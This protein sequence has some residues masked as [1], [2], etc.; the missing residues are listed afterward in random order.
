VDE[1]ALSWMMNGHWM[2][3][4]LRAENILHEWPD[5]RAI[6]ILRACRKTMPINSGLLVMESVLRPANEPGS[7]TLMDMT[8]LVLHGGLER[9]EGEYGSLLRGSAFVFATVRVTGS[10]VD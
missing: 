7:D 3:R 5:E 2:T 1:T 6:A 4:N 9:A 10:V 8:M